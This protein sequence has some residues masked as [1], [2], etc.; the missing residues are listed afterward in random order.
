MGADEEGTYERLKAHL[1]QLVN[2]KIEEYHG[3]I[4][5]AHR[6]VAPELN[7]G[8]C[9]LWDRRLVILLVIMGTRS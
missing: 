6:R 4:V 1:Q 5:K 9:A 7:E 3:R 8:S 2:P